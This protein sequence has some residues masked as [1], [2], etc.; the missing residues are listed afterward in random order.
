M[1]EPLPAPNNS[2]PRLAFVGN[3]GISWNGVDKL[4]AFAEKVPDIQVD[5][6]GYSRKDIPDKEIP[7]NVVLHGFVSIEKVREILSQVDV[8][9]GTLALSSKAA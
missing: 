8:A 3:A 5:I 4:I 7:K 6:I 9:S 2:N 1:I